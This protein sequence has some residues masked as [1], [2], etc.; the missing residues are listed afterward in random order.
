M[1]AGK[2]MAVMSFNILTTRAIGRRWRWTHRREAVLEAIRAFD[3]DVVGLQEARRP[4]LRFLRDRLVGFDVVSIGRGG[5][6]RL[7]EHTPVLFRRERFEKRDEGHFWL[8]PTPDVRGS[9]WWWSLP[10]RVASWVRLADRANDGREFVAVNTHLCCFWRRARLRGARLI[11]QHVS[12]LAGGGACVVTGDFN[13]TLGGAVHDELTRAGSEG[14]TLREAVSEAS[15]EVGR[16]RIDWI[17]CSEHFDVVD[18]RIDRTR[19]QGRIPSDH[20]PVT[21]L[22]AWGEGMG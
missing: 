3:G 6:E 9:R 7:G 21:A 1:T 20:W 8:G 18:A 15:V 17:L 11:R 5:G 16:R 2:P 4:Q 22:L 10:A 19:R 14:A 13:A 12:A